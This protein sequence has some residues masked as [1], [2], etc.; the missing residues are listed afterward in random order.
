MLASPKSSNNIKLNFLDLDACPNVKGETLGELNVRSLFL[1][2]M[3]I[4]ESAVR[5]LAPALLV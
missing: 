4:S 2:E 3:N 1:E 5:G